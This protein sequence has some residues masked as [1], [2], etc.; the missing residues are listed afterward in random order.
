ME[1]LMDFVT[2]NDIQINISN[3]YFKHLSL[4]TPL[5]FIKC[6]VC[7]LNDITMNI[8]MSGIEKK[9]SKNIH[10]LRVLK[11]IRLLLIVMPYAGYF[12]RQSVKRL[13]FYS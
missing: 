11:V 12:V 7:N 10:L 1:I 5:F 4:S 3:F 9:T 13:L 6:T 2:R 8:R